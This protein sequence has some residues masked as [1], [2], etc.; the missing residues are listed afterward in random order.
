MKLKGQCDFVDKMS[1]WPWDGGFFSAL[2]QA[3]FIDYDRGAVAV[4]KAL[5]RFKGSSQHLGGYPG[6]LQIHG[7]LT[8]IDGKN[9]LAVFIS[10]GK[11]CLEI[12]CGA[13]AVFFV[14]GSGSIEIYIVMDI[15]GQSFVGIFYLENAADGFRLSDFFIT[16]K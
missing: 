9:I 2:S 7:D 13:R 4:F 14:P 6:N 11:L 10:E 1:K 8:E 5:F 12:F 3:V 15:G 16:V